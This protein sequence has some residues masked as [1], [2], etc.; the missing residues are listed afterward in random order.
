MFRKYLLAS[1]LVVAAAF[2]IGGCQ[3]LFTD[4]DDLESADG[5]EA[6]CVSQGDCDEGQDCVNGECVGG[7]ECNNSDDCSGELI[8]V[9]QECVVD[10]NGE[11]PECTEE[12]ANDDC[13]SGE[14]CVD[15][16]CV[17]EPLNSVGPEC[18]GEA[19]CDEDQV[20]NENGQCVDEVVNDDNGACDDDDDCGSGSF[21]TVDGECQTKNY[22]WIGIQDRTADVAPDRCDDETY[23]YRTDGAKLMFVE[24]RD[25]DGTVISYGDWVFHDGDVGEWGELAGYDAGYVLNGTP[26]GFDFCPETGFE[27][28]IESGNYTNFRTDTVWP[29]GCNSAVYVKFPDDNN[30]PLIIEPGFEVVVGEYGTM[31]AEACADDEEC[32]HEPQTA[33]D[34]YQVGLC[35]GEV[36]GDG[37]PELL[38]CDVGLGEGEALSQTQSLYVE[39]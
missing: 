33:N 9:D 17:E 20:C 27:E 15:E 32:G 1:S 19:D 11:D 16:K 7:P 35:Y 28:N 39:Y 24:L 21:C 18:M 2:F 4:L 14:V 25:G 29:I 6:Q 30:E 23:G 10:D 38:N 5:D 36:D 13:D 22:R 37:E 26:H 31:C 3:G 12:T 34:Y 8:C